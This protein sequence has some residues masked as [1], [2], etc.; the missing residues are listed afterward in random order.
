MEIKSKPF[1]EL[2]YP[3]LESFIEEV[4]RF[5]NENGRLIYDKHKNLDDPI[6]KQMM[7]NDDLFDY[8]LFEAYKNEI[9]RVNALNILQ[10]IEFA[11]ISPESFF[12]YK[13]GQ[14]FQL[15]ENVKGLVSEMAEIKEL[16]EGIKDSQ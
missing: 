7:S 15:Y 1:I 3:S 6:K 9:F 10:N 4:S 2:Q 11:T 13:E 5:V 8:Q 16:L 14:K 12:M